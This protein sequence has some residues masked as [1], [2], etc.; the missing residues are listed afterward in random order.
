M[1]RGHWKKGK[2]R[3]TIDPSI[4][5]RNLLSLHSARHLATVGGVSDR[6]IRRWSLGE[7]WCEEDRIQ[8]LIDGLFPVNVGSCPIYSPDMAIDGHTR[9][10]GVG[11]FSRRAARGESIREED[12][13]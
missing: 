4:F 9:L 5:I 8:R 12:E 11:Q 3:A 7:D 6:T 1:N 13:C 2:R 10:V